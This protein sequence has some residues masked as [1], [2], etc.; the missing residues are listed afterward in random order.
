MNS[1]PHAGFDQISRSSDQIVDQQSYIELETLQ[2]SI[3]DPP[4]N[5][6]PFSNTHPLPINNHEEENTGG[7]NAPDEVLNV[8]DVDDHSEVNADNDQNRQAE[9]NGK[10]INSQNLPISDKL[11]LL[12]KSVSDI[13][14]PSHNENSVD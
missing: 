1:Q 11:D 4:I 2:D 12:N 9:N 6:D 14:P 5:E 8:P 10:S 13:E 7:Q 3:D